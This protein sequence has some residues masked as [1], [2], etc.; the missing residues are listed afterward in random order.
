MEK[1]L[2][3][4]E[5]CTLCEWKCGANRLEGETGVCRV[6]LPEVASCTLH[7]APP[8]SY[9][10]FLA[11]CNYKCLNC[12]NWTISQYPDNKEKLRYEKIRG[13]VEPKELA[14]E[15]LRNLNSLQ[16]KRIGADRI[17][18]SGGEPTIN[19]PYI[20]KIVEEA[21]KIDPSVKVN[22]DTNGF[23]TQR[24]LKR[25][26]DFTTSIT[27]DIKAYHD[28]VHRAITGA[29]A[30]PVLR[31]AEYIAKNAK[32]KL[33]E[34]RVLVIPKVNEDEIK[35]LSEFLASIHKSLQ[36]CFLAFRPNFVLENHPG[37]S[38]EL[39]ERCVEIANQ[40]GLD[41]AYWSGT[42]GLSGEVLTIEDKVEDKYE[43][44]EAK[45]A[46]SYAYKAGCITHP[47]SCGNCGSNQDCD[48]KRY[49]PLDEESR[50]IMRLIRF[51]KDL[52]EE[53]Q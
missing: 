47:R 51:V 39:M 26:L 28:E 8:Q 9:T 48:V 50:E 18:F 49:I 14:E 15:C 3:E 37:A 52:S 6:T 53:N 19:L 23:L 41:N 24:S 27:Y 36:V 43:I 17:F 35:P 25:V 5:N 20:E 46:A 12:Q 38:R 29:P 33:W 30:E 31:N 34:Y 21:R 4:L 13:Y 7:P 11:G 42:P 32:D 45:R 16:G 10:I 2:K 22:F 1:Y 44:E 40:A